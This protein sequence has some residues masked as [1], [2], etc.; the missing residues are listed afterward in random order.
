M[1]KFCAPYF[2]NTKFYLEK[3]NK[4]I[5]EAKIVMPYWVLSVVFP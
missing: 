2:E 1:K 3:G 4:L 5:L